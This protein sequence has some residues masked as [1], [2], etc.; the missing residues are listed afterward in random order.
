M[1]LNSQPGKYI[2]NTRI[3]ESHKT[4]LKTILQSQEKKIGYINKR[5][6]VGSVTPLLTTVFLVIIRSAW[7]LLL[8]PSPKVNNYFLIPGTQP[9]C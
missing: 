5:D 2:P 1:F 7:T 6:V 4:V 9:S 3:H 8:D